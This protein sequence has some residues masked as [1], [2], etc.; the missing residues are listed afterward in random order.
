M[1]SS[2]TTPHSLDSADDPVLYH[3]KLR[4]TPWMW[5]LVVLFGVLG[6][7]VLAPINVAAGI[8]SAVVLALITVAILVGMGSEIIVTKQFLQ[9]GRAGIERRFVG[10]VTGYRGDDAFEQR[11]QKLHGL[12]Y[13]NLRSWASPV[14]RIQITD[15][16]DRTPYWLTSTRNPEQLV[17]ALGGAMYARP[18]DLEDENIP[19][20]LREERETQQAQQRDDSE[21]HT[22]TDSNTD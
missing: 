18:E 7:M 8:G 14:V 6:Y 13:T 9:V 10:N 16:R 2:P 1:S 3:E 11:G 21:G 12:A 15:E 22:P 4:A 20:W 5:L 17:D 19:D